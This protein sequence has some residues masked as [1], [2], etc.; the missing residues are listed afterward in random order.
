[1]GWRVTV[2]GESANTVMM[3][4]SI[5]GVE[6]GAGQHTI[7]FSYRSYPHYPWL[8]LLGA[9]ALLSLGLWPR[10][11]HVLVYAQRVARRLRPQPGR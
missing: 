11:E 3:A 8:F 5:V 9:L 7:R 4:P 10:R 2:D 1:P 6:V